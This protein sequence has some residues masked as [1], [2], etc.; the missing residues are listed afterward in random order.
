MPSQRKLASD[1]YVV[2]GERASPVNEFTGW[3]RRAL[4][5]YHHVVT[6]FKNRDKP[7]ASTSR[8]HFA[9]LFSDPG[10]VCTTRTRQTPLA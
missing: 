9:E 3:S 8:C 10:V 6:S 2:G 1:C 4:G 7:P 5:R